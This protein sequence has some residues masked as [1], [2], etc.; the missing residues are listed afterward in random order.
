MKIGT[1]EKL[2]PRMRYR[3]CYEWTDSC[4]ELHS[5]KMR[6]MEEP[7]RSLNMHTFP[8]VRDMDRAV[9]GTPSSAA[10]RNREENSGGQQ[11]AERLEPSKGPGEKQEDLGSWYFQSYNLTVLTL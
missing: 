6:K 10:R 11:A 7:R 9:R 1:L 8:S 3:R 5:T 4:W 2:S